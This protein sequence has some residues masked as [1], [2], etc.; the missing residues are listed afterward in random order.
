[1]SRCLTSYRGRILQNYLRQEA[2][3]EVYHIAGKCRS[4][5]ISLAFISQAKFWDLSFYGAAL[6]LLMK[7]NFRHP[8]SLFDLH[9]GVCKIISGSSRFRAGR[10]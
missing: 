10:G 3:V 7:A 4:S 2:G 6:K 5:H 8:L 1:M 9:C